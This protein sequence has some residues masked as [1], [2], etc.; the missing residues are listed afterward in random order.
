M[1]SFRQLLMHSY[2]IINFV[3]LSNNL[4]K[5]VIYTEESIH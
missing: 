5:C 4:Q 1:N 2:N 3:Q